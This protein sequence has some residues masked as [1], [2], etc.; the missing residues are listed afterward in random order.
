MKLLPIYKFF[1]GSQTEF[2][3][4]FRENEQLF[5]QAQHFWNKLENSSLVIILICV[6][7]GI[8]LAAYYYL[9]YNNMP[10]RHYTPKH[11]I[12]FLVSTFILVFAVTLGFEYIA[13]PP[14][15]DG[16]FIL[17]LR[18]ALGN[19]VYATFLFLLISWMWCQFNLPTNAYR[20][21]KI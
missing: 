17:E 12:I 11:W 21:I 5:K 3:K 6:V 20:L 2:T 7:L 4:P 18:I 8:S 9:L 10:G 15:L 13:V 19:A 14:K 16:S 1:A